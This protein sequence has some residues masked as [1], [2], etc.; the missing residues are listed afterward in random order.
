MPRGLRPESHP[1]GA[2]PAVQRVAADVTVKEIV[3]RNAAQHVVATEGLDAVVAVGGD[4][5]LAGVRAQYLAHRPP[6]SSAAI[7]A[8]P[9][10]FRGGAFTICG[11]GALQARLFVCFGSVRLGADMLGVGHRELRRRPKRRE[12]SWAWA[13]EEQD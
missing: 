7:W 4:Q 11:M 8:S 10:S 1:I 6:S 2:G 13:D 5:D 9:G 3:P 12:P